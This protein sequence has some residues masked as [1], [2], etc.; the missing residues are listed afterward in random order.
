[1][2]AFGRQPRKA[3]SEKGGRRR[4]GLGAGQ[5]RQVGGLVQRSAAATRKLASSNS[6]CL[7]TR[8]RQA[9]EGHQRVVGARVGRKRRAAAAQLEVGAEVGGAFVA[10]GDGDAAVGSTKQQRGQRGQGSAFGKVEG[11]CFE[12]LRPKASITLPARLSL[13]SP[14]A[15]ATS[16]AALT[17]LHT[18]ASARHGAASVRDAVDGTWE[19]AVGGVAWAVVKGTP[20]VRVVTCARWW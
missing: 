6:S 13:A 7:K 4:D 10:R 2:S 15:A 3:L 1:M 12:P 16:P 20:A 9:L 17:A 8:T 11:D 5:G 14:S 19:R 18:S